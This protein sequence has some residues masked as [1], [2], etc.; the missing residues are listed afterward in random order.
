MRSRAFEFHVTL[1]P[2]VPATA[3]GREVGKKST[4]AA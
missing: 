3:S 1:P 2:H 4:R